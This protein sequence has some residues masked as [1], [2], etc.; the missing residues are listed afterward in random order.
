MLILCLFLSPRELPPTALSRMSDHRSPGTLIQK[1][2]TPELRCDRHR[3]LPDRQQQI[4][5]AKAG[6]VKHDFEDGVGVSRGLF[7]YKP[8]D[9]ERASHHRRSSAWQAERSWKESDQSHMQQ[10]LHLEAATCNDP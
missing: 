5:C 9:A 10:M 2:E 8:A 1:E 7:L 3:H 6:S 4:V